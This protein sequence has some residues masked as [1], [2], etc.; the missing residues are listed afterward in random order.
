MNLFDAARMHNIAALNQ[1]GV[2]ENLQKTTHA[3]WLQ[4]REQL[5]QTAS[6]VEFCFA[7][8]ERELKKWGVTLDL[9]L[10]TYD[11]AMWETHKNRTIRNFV[12]E[13][14]PTSLTETAIQILSLMRLE[15]KK[16]VDWLRD[17]K[18]VVLAL[19]DEI[20]LIDAIGTFCDYGQKLTRPNRVDMF[21]EPLKPGYMIFEKK[22]N[23]LLQAGYYAETTSYGKI[24]IN[25][26]N[27]LK[28][29]N[30]KAQLMSLPASI[31]ITDV[32]SVG[33]KAI[34]DEK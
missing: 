13:G 31:Y 5:K 29:Y 22:G 23:R 4:T 21:G 20:E 15:Y 10:Y 19:S 26:R 9:L 14:E 25:N 27:D 16:G 3:E 11:G 17:L 6:D 30:P 33:A 24:M 32:L 18:R 1:F 7:E 12:A 34:Q 2:F 28:G 8:K